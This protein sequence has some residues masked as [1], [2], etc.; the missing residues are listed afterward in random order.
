M[1]GRYTQT[2]DIQQLRL[3]FDIDTV[4]EA[5][6]PRY[7]IAPS[8][9]APVIVWDNG[10]VLKQM[11]WGLIPR[12]AR[13]EKVGNKMINARCETLAEKPSFK[14]L[15]ARNRCLVLADGFYEWRATPSKGKTPIRIVL[16]DRRPFAFAGLWDCWKRDDGQELETFTI[17]T[18][19]ANDLIKDYH[20]RMP[21][22]L[23]RAAS[24][25]W[26]KGND[27]DIQTLDE[28]LL[29]FPA[30]EMELYEVPRMVNSPSHDSPDCIAPIPL[31]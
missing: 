16:K 15:L 23:D 18:T 31:K 4:M 20:L 6:Q 9:V 27:L 3:H 19:I 24:D 11:R 10:S 26:L 2:G 22:I 25:I 5:P 13:N 21:V 1:C 28:I 14:S 30:E 7:N 12:W 29:P 8:Q 17:V